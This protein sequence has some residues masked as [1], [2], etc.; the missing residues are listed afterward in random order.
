MCYKQLLRSHQATNRCGREGIAVIIHL[1]LYHTA[2]V[3]RKIINRNRHK[4]CCYWAKPICGAGY[5]FNEGRKIL[6][7]TPRVSGCG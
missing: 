2:A 6:V 5:T 1:L 7:K 4:L 3:L